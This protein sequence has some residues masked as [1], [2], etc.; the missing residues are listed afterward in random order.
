MSTRTSTFTHKTDH[1]RPSYIH[2]Y[3]LADHIRLSYIHSYFLKHHLRC[4]MIMWEWECQECSPFTKETKRNSSYSGQGQYGTRSVQA[5]HTMEAHRAATEPPPGEGER[6]PTVSTKSFTSMLAS[7]P[8]CSVWIMYLLQIIEKT[9]YY[10]VSN[11]FN[12][13]AYTYKCAHKHVHVCVCA[14]VYPHVHVHVCIS[15]NTECCL[16]VWVFVCVWGLSDP[17]IPNSI[18]NFYQHR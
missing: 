8:S 3:F 13:C 6:E 10:H 7:G 14:C 9:L 17:T 18:P 12:L 15:M 1:I 5:K 2:S 4:L 11:P 16:S